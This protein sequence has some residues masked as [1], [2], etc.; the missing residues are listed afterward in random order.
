MKEGL[1]MGSMKGTEKQLYYFQP[2][3]Y[4]QTKQSE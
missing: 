3:I 1:D 2:E 4:A